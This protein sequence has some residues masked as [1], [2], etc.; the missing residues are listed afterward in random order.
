MRFIADY[1]LTDYDATVLVGDKALA[2]YFEAAVVIAGPQNAKPICNWISNELL[3]HLNASKIDISESYVDAVNLAF[4]V[5]AINE[6]RLTARL[7]KD[8]IAEAFAKKI[9]AQFQFASVQMSD[10]ASISRYCDEAIAEM[11]KA[12]QE[13][14][15][16]KER[17]IGSIVGLVMKKSQGKANPQLVNR[18]L[19]KKLASRELP[20]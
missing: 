20:K 19:H 2:A 11:P 4:L 12:V 8:M 6:H 17:A 10:E 13:Y 9:H 18:V 5:Q 15:A 16:G 14:K 1:K 3:G 7:A